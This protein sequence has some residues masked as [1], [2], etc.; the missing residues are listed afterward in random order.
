MT[1]PPAPP[2]P[3][4]TRTP[5]SLTPHHA[6]LPPTSSTS[7]RALEVR[8]QGHAALRGYGL[9]VSWD[10]RKYAERGRTEGLC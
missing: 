6:H 1:T 10:A 9:V 5:N 3:T 8:G 4:R 7:R 2:A